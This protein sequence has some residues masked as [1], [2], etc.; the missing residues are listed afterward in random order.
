[1]KPPAEWKELK[2]KIRSKFG[3]LSDCEIEGLNGHMGKL[4]NKVQG[5]YNYSVEKAK[6]ETDSFNES[7]QKKFD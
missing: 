5:A 7:I 4:Q 3:R 2:R 1:M 6:Q